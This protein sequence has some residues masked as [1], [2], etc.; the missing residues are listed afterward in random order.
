MGK[1][2]KIRGSEVA[3]FLGGK[4][5]GADI[6]IENVVSL[7]QLSENSLSFARKFDNKYMD[8]INACTGSIVIC[9]EDY[10]D[11]VNSSYIISDNPG[12]DFLR[13]VEEFFVPTKESGIDKSAKVDPA[14]TIGKDVFVGA[15]SVIGPDVF[16]G[17]GTRV[18]H[19]VVIIGRVTIGSGCVIKSG[20][21]I[22]EEGFGFEYSEYGVPEH[23]PHIGSIEI[24]DNVWVGSG[25]TIERAHIHKTVIKNNVKIDDLVQ[26]GHNCVVGEN[27]LITCG[28]VIC[29]AAVIGKNCWIAPNSSIRERISIGEGAFVGLGS[30]VVK[31]VDEKIIVAGNPARKLKDR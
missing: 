31:D 28:T 10:K 4:L 18:H 15:N 26:V 14:A 1:T 21:I 25:S 5:F 11:K 17:D 23:F 6:L 20:A 29:G 2:N 12:L 9:C 7:E 22:G 19:N 27:S 13:T 24:G 3:E 16:I 8:I 30:V